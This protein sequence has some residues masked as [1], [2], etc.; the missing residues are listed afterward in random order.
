VVL[1]PQSTGT[2]HGTPNI[3]FR[4]FIYFKKHVSHRL[5]R[6]YLGSE[7]IFGVIS[8][9]WLR[10]RPIPTHRASATVVFDASLASGSNASGNNQHINQAFIHGAKCVRAILQSG[11]T[12]SNCRL[13]EGKEI[14]MTAADSGSVF[15]FMETNFRSRFRSPSFLLS[16]PFLGDFL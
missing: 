11:L 3:K 15:A 10:V 13:V 6:L 5:V 4:F 1:V 8:R 2:H 9:A 12:P 16:F 7:G 14:V